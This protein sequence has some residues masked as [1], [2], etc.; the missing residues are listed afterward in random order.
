[1]KK[2]FMHAFMIWM[3]VYPIVTLLLCVMQTLDLSL[4]TGLKSL[5]MTLILVP[6][7]YFYIVPFT[8]RLLP[9]WWR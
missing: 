6:L 2:S 1:M 5:V 4:A 8:N 9:S 3:L 7:M